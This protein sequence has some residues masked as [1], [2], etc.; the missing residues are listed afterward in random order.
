M[1][2]EIQLLLLLAIIIA[3]SKVA[4]H[5]SRRFLKQPVVF[6]EILAGLLLGPSLLNIFGWPVF[7]DSSHGS[8]LQENIHTLASVGV[9]LL[10]FIAGL[11][12]DLAKMREVGKAACWTAICGVILP[13]GLGIAVATLFGLTL[14]ESIFIGTVLTATSVSITA[15]TLMEIGRL[16]G[17]EGMTILGAAVIDDVLGII[18]LSFVIAFG[19]AESASGGMHSIRLPETLAH[20]AAQALGHPGA[21]LALQIVAVIVLMTTFFALAIRVG[22]RWMEP[23]LRRVQHL[24]A[25]HAVP[26]AALLLLLL[27][28]VGAEYFGQVAAI[29][30]AYL[31]GVFLAR[32]RFAKEIEHATHPFTYALFVPV[33][34]MSIG[35]GANARELGASLWFTIAVIVV[36]IVSK[37]AGGGIGARWMGFTQREALRVGIG[38]ISRGEVGLIIALV[39]KD[40]GIIRPPEYAALVIMVLV[41]TV[42]TPVFLR[43]SFPRTVAIEAEVY[44][45]VV[46]VETDVDK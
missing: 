1:N 15:Q 5:L 14:T 24:H 2:R 40:A 30:G 41:T 26:A 39:G 35:L 37:I 27:F 21:E 28:A 43:L 10:M 16:A 45:S 23:F 42:A 31:A 6:G 11:E 7:A 44:E 32:T 46:A 12:T 3:V 8:W 18:V 17:K 19:S 33:F 9:L 34:F 20:W 13:L 25:S 29:T 4:G 22:A 38:M 36:A